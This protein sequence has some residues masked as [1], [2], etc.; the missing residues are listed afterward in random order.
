MQL[1]SPPIH[2]PHPLP[3]CREWRIRIDELHFDSS[4]AK[5]IVPNSEWEDRLRQDHEH[6]QN[7]KV[8]QYSMIASIV[9]T[10]SGAK[11]CNRLGIPPH[12]AGLDRH[13]DSAH[14]PCFA[15][16]LPE[17]LQDDVRFRLKKTP[18]EFPGAG[19]NFAETAIRT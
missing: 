3:L 17:I 4:T 9:S 7:I 8:W 5:V 1:I 14:S 13:R 6:A 11:R 12:Y 19:Q 10:S 16:P 18:S 15:K 2:G